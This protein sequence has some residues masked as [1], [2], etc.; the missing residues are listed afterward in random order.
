MSAKFMS[1][2]TLIMCF[3]VLCMVPAITEASD[4][5]VKGKYKQSQQQ[6]LPG[7]PSPSGPLKRVP[8]KKH[9]KKK[10]PSSQGPVKH[11]PKSN[12]TRRDQAGKHKHTDQRKS[13]K[14]QPRIEHRKSKKYN[15]ST[16]THR[17]KP[18]HRT[19]S[20]HDHH[21]RRYS[22]KY[23]RHHHHRHE[24]YHYHTRYLA[25]IHHH[26]HPIGFHVTF[27]PHAHVRIFI[28]GIPYFYYGGIYYRHRSS[29]YVV[30]RAP[31]GAIVH[32]LPIGFITFYIG[33]VSY[34]YVNDVY[35]RWDDDYEAYIVVVKPRAAD[36]AIATATEGRL[37]IYPNH[38]QSEE[39]QA[40]DRYECHRWAV[41]ETRVDPTLDE[42]DELTREEERN[43][44]RALSAC[45]QGRD[46]TVK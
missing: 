38:G 10:N 14:Q 45:L 35:Y 33:G 20:S 17:T 40:K 29:G 7:E 24:T 18:R 30:V 26:Y 34:Y 9:D 44:K 4:K 28:H 1:W 5:Q 46:Y 37:F 41:S 11:K 16:H 25:P 39:Q 13:H 12:K 3:S 23:R 21:Y 43:Y 8:S 6:F 42:E 31:I 32:E 27:L 36:A 19:H 22:T 2:H 15:K